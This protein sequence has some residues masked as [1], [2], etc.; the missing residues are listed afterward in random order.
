MRAAQRPGDDSLAVWIAF[1]KTPALNFSSKPL[2]WRAAPSAFDVARIMPARVRL[3]P[4]DSSTT[5]AD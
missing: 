5:I 2:H 3:A 4:F 1:I